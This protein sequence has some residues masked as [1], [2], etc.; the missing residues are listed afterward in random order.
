MSTEAFEDFYF[1]VCAGVDYRAMEKAMR[2]LG[3]LM[4]KTDRVHITGPGTDLHFSIKDIGAI[5]CFGQRNIPDG[6]IF[7]C[8]V[9][10]SVN[11]DI[12]FNCETLYRGTVFSGIRLEF[13]NGK[14]DRWRGGFRRHDRKAQRD[15]RRRRR[16]P[17]HRRMEPCFQP[18]HPPADE[19]HPLRRKN[20]RQLSTSP[21]AKPT[22]KPTTATAARSIGTWSASNAKTGAAG[23][24]GSMEN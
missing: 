14:V 7:T 20:R 17:L 23:K 16:R 24:S 12:Q 3:D 18:A 22:K 9:R 6:E 11:G 1:R 2:P 10:D 13:K 5:G 15:S 4:R 8:P 21:P 19:G